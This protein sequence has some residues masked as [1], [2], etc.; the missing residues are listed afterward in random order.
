MVPAH[1]V[2]LPDMPL[3]P[4]GKVDRKRLPAPEQ[5]RSGVRAPY[6][7]PRTALEKVLAAIW[8]DVLKTQEIG[9]EDDFFELGGHSILATQLFARMTDTLQAKIP[10]RA[11]FDERTIANLARAMLAEAPDRA[12][13][14]L[15]AEVVLQVLGMSEDEA[16]AALG[17]R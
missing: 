7:A 5:D 6:V 14:E 8:R 15:T 11:I 9:V 1:F 2:L 3:L 17:R 4:N 10:L 16:A 12:R 13:L